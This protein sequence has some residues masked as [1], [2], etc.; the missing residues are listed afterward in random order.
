MLRAT[1][2]ELQRNASREF[3]PVIMEA[4]MYAYEA[5]TAERGKHDFPLCWRGKRILT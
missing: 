1:I 4:M 2:T 3:T 5:C